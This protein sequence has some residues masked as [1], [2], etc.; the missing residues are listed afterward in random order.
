M[1]RSHD[2][3][4]KSGAWV[5]PPRPGARWVPDKWSPGYTTPDVPGHWE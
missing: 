4:W 3:I 2:Y 5:I 1:W